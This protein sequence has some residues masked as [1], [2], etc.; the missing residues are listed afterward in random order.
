MMY[1]AV[2]SNKDGVLSY[3]VWNRAIKAP[4][5]YWPTF[6]LANAIAIDLNKSMAQFERAIAKANKPK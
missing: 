4:H 3:L 5:S 1:V 6:E 2:C